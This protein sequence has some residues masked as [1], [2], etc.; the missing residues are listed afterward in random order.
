MALGKW[1]GQD[2]GGVLGEEARR[3]AGS[4]FR[5]AGDVVAAAARGIGFYTKDVFCRDPQIS[6]GRAGGVSRAGDRGRA[7]PVHGG[8]A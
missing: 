4:H 5:R 2:G 7:S 6:G 8:S 1:S 3:Q